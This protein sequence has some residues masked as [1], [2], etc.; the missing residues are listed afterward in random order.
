MLIIFLLYRKW[1]ICGPW[2]RYPVC[3][4]RMTLLPTNRSS[5]VSLLTHSG[6]GHIFVQYITICFCYFYIIFYV[7]Q[8]SASPVLGMAN[9][10]CHQRWCTFSSQWV[11]TL[12]TSSEL[13]GTFKYQLLSMRSSGRVNR[14]FWTMWSTQLEI[15][16]YSMWYT[17]RRYHCLW[18]LAKFC[19]YEQIWFLLGS[20]TQQ[21]SL[22]AI[23]MQTTSAGQMNY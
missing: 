17:E 2:G 19:I 7:F 10:K 9:L 14:F 15:S 5:W 16:S 11:I 21:W 12:R 4:K 13:T 22:K 3:S 8:K 1:H 23:Y 20:S 6:Q 18:R